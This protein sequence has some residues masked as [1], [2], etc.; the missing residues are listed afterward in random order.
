MPIDFKKPYESNEFLNFLT[1]FLPNDFTRD[2]ESIKLEDIT[3]KPEKI[4]KV[5]MIGNVPSLQN[6][7][8]YEI[9]HESEFDPRVTLSRETFRLMSNFGARKALAVFVSK[10]SPNY[11]F[12]LASIDLK[13]EGS[14]V[15]KEYSN[16]RR[17]SYF[18]GPDAKIH[19]PSEYLIKNGQLF[20]FNDL[21]SRFS[22]EVVNKEFYS[23]IAELFTN[24]TGGKRYIGNREINEKGCIQLPGNPK[25]EIK[26]EFSV[27]LIGRLL[28]CWFLKK[29]YSDN[30][31]PL[32]TDEI[33]SL[34]SVE[35]N[36]EYY[37]TILEPLFFQVLNT[38]FDIRLS[39]YKQSP[40]NIVPFL[41][42]GL[43]APHNDDYYEVGNLGISKSINTLKIPDNWIYKLIQVFE[44]Y[45]F[46]ID[47][48]TAIDVELSIDPEMLGR[49]FENLL[50]E[51][52]PET[53]ETARKSTGSY[54]TPRLIV[55]YMVDESLK[56]Y[57]LNKIKLA[58]E[59]IISLLSYEISESNLTD[60]E[61]ESVINALDT[62]KVIDPACGSGAF[63]MGILQK[64]ILILQKVDPESK[65]WLSKKL[66]RIDNRALRNDA[67]EKLKN[68]N[69]NYVHKLGIIQ[70]AIY[71]VD[72]QPIA[73]E[74]SKLRF[75]LSLIVDSRIDDSKTNRG[76][77]PLPNLEFKF[78][79][80]NS[81]IGLQQKNTP[82]FE[83]E[84]EITKLMNLRD[85]YFSTYGDDKEH[86]QKEFT[87]TQIRMFEHSLKMTS[88]DSQTINLSKWNPFS[89]EQSNWFDPFWMFGIKDRF[90]IVI[91]NPPYIDSETMV[92]S[93]QSKLR[94]YISTNYT[95]AKGNW[96]IYIAFFDKGF[97]ILNN[98]GVLIFITPDKWLSKPF[99]YELRTRKKE[100][101]KSILKCGR[102]IFEASTVDSII[103]LFLENKSSKLRIYD[104]YD[105]KIIFKIELDKKLIKEPYNLDFCFSNHLDLLLK[106]STMPLSLTNFG[107]CENACATS[108]AYKLKS[109]LK[110]LKEPYNETK[111]FKLINTGT[112]GRYVSKWG[113]KAMRYIKDDYIFPAVERNVFAKSFT[114]TY[115]KKSV[116]PKIIIKGLTLLDACLDINGSVIPGKTTLIVTSKNNDYLKILLAIINSKLTAFYMNE[117]YPSS[118]Y[119]QGIAF[120]C[121]MLN[122]F[123]IPHLSESI[124]RTIISLI[125]NILSIAKEKD[126]FDD[127]S[128][129]EK[130]NG[131]ERQIDQM[132]YKLYGLT[133]EEIKY[134]E[135]HN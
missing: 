93:G 100:N 65:K 62:I 13:L 104:F 31:V 26:K 66:A 57:L 58:D 118:S 128:K 77:I 110:D 98:T 8:I 95:L 32:L 97:S 56:Q 75:F 84:T 91:A 49:V 85:A 23:K 18:L 43:F 127:L 15:T 101:I 64:M 107:I 122:N 99:G 9:E 70:N 55:E 105:K 29:K 79:C 61:K 19:T 47:E 21:E 88:T 102:D 10:K 83:A 96:D 3:F 51:I 7:R 87:M 115:V 112:I 60:I 41:N 109:I 45:N 37:H 35:Q 132:V 1:N 135:D 25:D 130:V 86:I 40:W 74:I 27:R 92:N 42:G 129:Q 53:G 80:A 24:L 46:T 68:E 22:I 78:V 63:P 76:I 126:Y 17:Y 20:D 111:Y 11:R 44:T 120:T 121:D 59:K 14:R 34:V 48:N 131:Y 113:K 67:E 5:K 69:W 73:S 52:N 90:D 117:K 36:D 6:L 54:Y 123:P 39:K 12:S 106:I 71:G 108:E 2:D 103:T 124:Q 89:N 33:L 28:F 72:I 38:P 16:P 119:N 116:T 4:K 81:L 30:G 133:Q 114:K 125:D 94:E 134:V 50:A 82:L